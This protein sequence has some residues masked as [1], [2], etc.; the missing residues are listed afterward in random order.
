VKALEVGEDAIDRHG[1][2]LATLLITNLAKFRHRALEHRE[3]LIEVGEVCGG[4]S[5][6]IDGNNRSIHS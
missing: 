6:P 1:Q 3:E 5:V 2:E 4:V